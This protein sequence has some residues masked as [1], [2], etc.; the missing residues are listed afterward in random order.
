MGQSVGKVRVRVFVCVLVAVSS[1]TS[2]KSVRKRP[3]CACLFEQCSP[4]TTVQEELHHARR[5]KGM[6][7]PCLSGERRGSSIKEPQ[8]SRDESKQ[9]SK[10]LGPRCC[11]DCRCCCLLFAERRRKIQVR[12][13]VFYIL[14]SGTRHLWD[15]P[16]DARLVSSVQSIHTYGVTYIQQHHPHTRCP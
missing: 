1:K 7:A 11:F 2:D 12:A 14:F 9:A 4:E 5:T 8:R 13:E 6:D 10:R 15:T 16:V 3:L